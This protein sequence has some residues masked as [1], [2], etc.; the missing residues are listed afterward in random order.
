MKIGDLVYRKKEIYSDKI[1]YFSDYCRAKDG[2]L[3]SMRDLAGVVLSTRSDDMPISVGPG[4]HRWTW[5]ESVEK[6]SHT[7]T[8]DKVWVAWTPDVTSLEFVDDLKVFDE[9]SLDPFNELEEDDEGR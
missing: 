5:D 6:D 4:R 9:D 2:T 3:T 1:L 7:V 8:D